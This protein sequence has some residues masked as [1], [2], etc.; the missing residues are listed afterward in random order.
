MRMSYFYHSIGRAFCNLVI[1]AQ[2]TKMIH[3]WKCPFHYPAF[4]QNLPL[5]ARNAL[6][7]IYTKIKLGS[8]G[9]SVLCLV[10]SQNGARAF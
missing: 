7:N 1:L 6:R 10:N 9:K 3:P 5:I 2:T 8:F 4:W